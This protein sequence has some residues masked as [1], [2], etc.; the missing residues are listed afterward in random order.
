MPNKQQPLSRWRSTHFVMLCLMVLTRREQALPN[1]MN[2]SSETSHL[3]QS[4]T[5]DD[6]SILRQCRYGLVCLRYTCTCLA[7]EKRWTATSRTV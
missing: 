6:T 1:C 7:I 4:V 3:V 5:S 2:T